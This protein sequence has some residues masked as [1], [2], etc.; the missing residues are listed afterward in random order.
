MYKPNTILIL[1]SDD[2]MHHLCIGNPGTEEHCHL[3]YARK[4]NYPSW[5]EFLDKAL[6]FLDVKEDLTDSSDNYS[7]EYGCE[8]CIHVNDPRRKIE[9]E[10]LRIWHYDTYCYGKGSN[11]FVIDN[12]VSI[13]N[14]G[15]QRWNNHVQLIETKTDFIFYNW[16]TSA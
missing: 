8:Q 2:E 1:A 13:I 15:L 14:I 6:A 3:V 4:N 10:S 11:T 9:L 5:E 12:I 7:D 16:S